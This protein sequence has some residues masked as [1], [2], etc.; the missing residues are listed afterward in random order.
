MRVFSRAL[1]CALAGMLVTASGTLAQAPKGMIGTWKINLA[2]SKFDPGPAPKSQT[3]TYA[4]EGDAVKITVNVTPAT[5]APQTWT[6]TAAYDGKDAKVTG[7]P[8]ADTISMKKINDTT[9]ESTFKK[10]GKVTTVNTRVLS[11]DGKT[12]TITTKGTNADGKPMHN[13]SVYDKQ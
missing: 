13:V 9:G 3:V 4:A 11:A 6:M 12:L 5:G 10:A 8:D 7:N 1:V 2:K